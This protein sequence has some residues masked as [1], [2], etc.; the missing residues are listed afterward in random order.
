MRWNE[1]MYLLAVE[2][3]WQAES[4]VTP[5]ISVPKTSFSIVISKPISFVPVLRSPSH[6]ITRSHHRQF[7]LLFH[8]RFGQKVCFE[9]CLAI[10]F[11][12]LAAV[13]LSSVV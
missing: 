3:D 7:I 5:S 12:V 9:F 2:S 1:K 10:L 11:M 6:A 13:P 4:I 8:H